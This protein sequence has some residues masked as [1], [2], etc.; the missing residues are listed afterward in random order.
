MFLLQWCDSTLFAAFHLADRASRLCDC[1]SL[2]RLSYPWP[3]AVPFVCACV[4][5]TCSMWPACGTLGWSRC[6]CVCAH[7]KS[8][9]ARLP[10][11][12]TWQ[13]GRDKGREKGREADQREERDREREDTQERKDEGKRDRWR[14]KCVKKRKRKFGKTSCEMKAR[15]KKWEKYLT[16]TQMKIRAHC[17]INKCRNLRNSKGSKKKKGGW[18]WWGEMN[19]GLKRWEE[20]SE[21][22]VMKMETLNCKRTEGEGV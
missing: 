1:V 19:E 15:Q 20:G 16:V 17:R 10:W 18:C 8:L 14:E 4:R 22:E 5:S 3:S 11:V 21:G 7:A 13:R 6:M 2:T 12:T 9:A